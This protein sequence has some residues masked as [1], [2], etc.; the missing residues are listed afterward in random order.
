MMYFCLSLSS[1]WLLLL[2]VLPPPA[3]PG[4]WRRWRWRQWRA[5]HDHLAP[6]HLGS[7]QHL[8]AARLHVHLPAPADSE[9]RARGAGGRHLPADGPRGRHLQRFHATALVRSRRDTFNECTLLQVNWLTG[10]LFSSRDIKSVR[11]P[12]LELD[13]RVSVA[14]VSPKGGDLPSPGTQRILPIES[15]TR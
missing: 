4:A 5:A 13:S 15:A 7:I 6:G 12:Q 9:H 3:P 14:S 10:S 11:R 2:A 8:P 1:Q